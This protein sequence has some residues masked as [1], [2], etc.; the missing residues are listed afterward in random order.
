MIKYFI[1]DAETNEWYRYPF[2]EI[3]TEHSSKYGWDKPEPL[4]EAYWT[5]NPNEAFSFFETRQQAEYYLKSMVD[6]DSLI[7]YKGDVGFEKRT[8]IITEHEFVDKCTCKK[9]IECCDKCS[10]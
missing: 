8:L 10:D 3:P 9:G 6:I 5:R 1:E 7:L 2:G 4:N